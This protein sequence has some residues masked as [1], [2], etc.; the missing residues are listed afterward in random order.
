MANSIGLRELELFIRRNLK[1]K[2]AH[3]FLNARML[4]EADLQGCVYAHICRFLR[5]D[6]RWRVFGCRYVPKI[7]RFLDLLIF[8]EGIPRI[9]MELKWMRRRISRKDRRSLNKALK[10]LPIK[11]AYFLTTNKHHSSYKKLGCL[12]R[13]QEKYRLHEIVVV[14]DCT[15]ARLEQVMAERAKYKAFSTACAA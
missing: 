1:V 11:K 15:T 10:E 8:C 6:S 13:A 3:D 7:S 9:A 2:L 14:P 4:R 12:K 5:S